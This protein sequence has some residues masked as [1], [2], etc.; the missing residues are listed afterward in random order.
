M[1]WEEYNSEVFSKGNKIN[2][3]VINGV[4]EPEP[5]LLDEARGLVTA[6]YQ[7]YLDAEWIKELRN[8]YDIEVDRKVLKKVK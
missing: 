8:K 1:T 2:L 7:T 3:V 4:L 5:K 6:D